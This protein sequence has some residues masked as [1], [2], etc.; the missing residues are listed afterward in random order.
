[1]GEE[2]KI[3]ERQEILNKINKIK[4]YARE[5]KQQQRDLIEQVTSAEITNS[6]LLQRVQEIKF[7]KTIAKEEFKKKEK[8][9]KF[10]KNWFGFELDKKLQ[11]EEEMLKKMKVCHEDRIKEFGKNIFST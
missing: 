6:H 3:I 7:R 9:L 10:E 4:H 2:E 8:E 5:M 11:E 1:M